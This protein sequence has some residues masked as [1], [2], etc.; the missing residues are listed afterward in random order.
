MLTLK[1]NLRFTKTYIRKYKKLTK[2]NKKLKKQISKTL[3]LLSSDPRNPS[4][5][6]H[7]VYAK[8]FGLRL[9]SS[10][11]ADLRVIWDYDQN[12]QLIILIL[13]IGTHSG[14]NRVYN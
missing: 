5:K 7:K 2:N 1:H 4:L 14:K 10:V 13:T 3:E 8:E 6:S 9:S 11:S 12:S